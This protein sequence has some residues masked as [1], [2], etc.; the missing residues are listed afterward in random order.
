MCTCPAPLP[1]YHYARVSPPY[2]RDDAGLAEKL[3]RSTNVVPAQP[4][5]VAGAAGGGGGA[6]AQG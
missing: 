5:A 4:E 6:E 2:V 3:D 1:A